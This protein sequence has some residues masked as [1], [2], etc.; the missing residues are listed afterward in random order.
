VK[1]APNLASFDAAF[2]SLRTRAKQGSN[3]ESLGARFGFYGL[4]VLLYTSNSNFSLSPSSPPHHSRCKLSTS[5]S[6]NT[7]SPLRPALTLSLFTTLVAR[8]VC[9]V[10]HHVMATMAMPKLTL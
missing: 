2:C 6:S 10:T 8:S 5:T 9:R 3:A 7:A 4:P 1:R